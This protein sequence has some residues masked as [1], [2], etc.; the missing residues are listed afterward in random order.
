MSQYQSARILVPNALDFY[1]IHQHVLSLTQGNPQ[2]TYA[3]LGTT[4][5]GVFVELRTPM[6][7]VLPDLPMTAHSIQKEDRFS[8]IGAFRFVRQTRF[9]ERMPTTEEAITKFVAAITAGGLEPVDTGFS[10]T[11]NRVRFERKGRSMQLPFWVIS[12]EVVVTDASLAAATMVR[13]V[14]R[15]RGLGF[16]MLVKAG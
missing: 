10:I 15:S 4:S 13:G 2:C 9:G 11:N 7:V 16:G 8:M 1:G 12:G 3:P 14:G 6:G 5:E